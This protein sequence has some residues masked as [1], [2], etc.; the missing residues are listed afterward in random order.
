MR[1]LVRRGLSMR[2]RQHSREPKGVMQLMAQQMTWDM[3]TGTIRKGEDVE[4][5][6]R[7]VLLGRADKEC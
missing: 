1:D 4:L 3:M 7:K 2:E 5:G 6:T